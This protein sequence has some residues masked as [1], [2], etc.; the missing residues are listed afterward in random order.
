MKSPLDQLEAR[1]QALIEGSVARLFPIARDREELG[2]HLIAAMRD[3]IHPQ[4]D[5]RQWAPNRFTLF[6]HPAQAQILHNQNH[7]LDDLAKLL[8]QAGVE[9]GLEF[10]SPPAIV[11][12]PDPDLGLQEMRILAQFQ[13]DGFGKT[14]TLI[15]TVEEG[16]TST[17]GNA[18]LI[19]DGA[20]VVPLSGGV[21]NIGRSSSNHLI[22]DDI[23]VSR[24]H[25][26]LRTVHGRYVIFDLD[27]TGG[28]YVNGQ[29]INQMVLYPGDVITLAGV[30]IIYGQ[31]SSGLSGETQEMPYLPEEPN[32]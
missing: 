14:S 3:N 2:S 23:R 25:A 5:G 21:I 28:T 9:A 8:H 12:A 7:V 27:S 20:Q 30:P 1:L 10:P 4:A 16:H 19:V 15:S 11:A 31:E 22:I 26:Q 29:R 17:P 32:R 13:L 18:F 24:S 6:I